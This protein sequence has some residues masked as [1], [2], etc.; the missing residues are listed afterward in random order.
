MPNRIPVRSCEEIQHYLP[1]YVVGSVEASVKEEIDVH[2][3]H[4]PHC[5]R[6]LAAM[7]QTVA[8]LRRDTIQQPSETYW[9]NLLPRIHQ[10]LQQA[11][12][13][14][15]EAPLWLHRFAIPFASLLIVILI[16]TRFVHFEES[17][18]SRPKDLRVILQ[19][20][21]SWDVHEYLAQ[22]RSVSIGENT[23]DRLETLSS[24]FDE[25]RIK[26][27]LARNLSEE[28]II[29]AMSGDVLFTNIE[30]QLEGLDEKD[31]ETVLIRLKEAESL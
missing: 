4:C 2:L 9:T 6:E 3:R 30:P 26:A 13:S 18:R 14:P 19:N 5:Q 7:E 11:Q 10:R 24:V 8:T 20:M 29:Q 17:V 31:I 23:V 12:H 1:D 16:L 15:K 22:S 28:G 21:D 25:E 27:I